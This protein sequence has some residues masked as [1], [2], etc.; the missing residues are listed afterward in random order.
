MQLTSWVPVP[1]DHYSCFWLCLLIW[2]I[3]VGKVHSSVKPH[4]VTLKTWDVICTYTSHSSSCYLS[5]MFW[6][7]LLKNFFGCVSWK[8]AAG[9]FLPDLVSIRSVSERFHFLESPW[10]NSPLSLQCSL[11]LSCLLFREVPTCVLQETVCLEHNFQS[12]NSSHY[13]PEQYL[14]HCSH[15]EE[16]S[17]LLK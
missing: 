11:H 10:A 14:Y 16:N 4:P 3:G 17:T 13:L 15:K 12:S 7:V 1:W 2:L 5:S 9:F 6:W 8:K